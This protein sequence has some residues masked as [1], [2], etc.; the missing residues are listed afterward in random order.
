MALA[1]D[2]DQL[3]LRDGENAG[4]TLKHEAVLRSLTQV[5]TVNFSG[6]F[7]RD[8]RM[9]T[10]S[11]NPQ[12]LRVVAIVQELAA[13]RVLGVGLTRFSNRP[14]FFVGT[15]RGGFLCPLRHSS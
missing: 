1:D 14:S 4:K 8:V 3:M 2:S 9:S 15:G 13:G 12:N 7:S 11:A 10:A 6:P 5:G